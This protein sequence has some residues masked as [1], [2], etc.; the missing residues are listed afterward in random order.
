MKNK[1]KLLKNI[2]AVALVFALTVTLFAPAA[3]LFF[4][5]AK[6]SPVIS[7]SSIIS[8]D[9]YVCARMRV[10]VSSFNFFIS[11]YMLLFINYHQPSAV[12]ILITRVKTPSS[13][14]V[15]ISPS[16]F[17]VVVSILLSPKP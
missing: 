13:H 9:W 17:F 8:G 16:Y 1:K 15:S 3:R 11:L 7:A 10:P 12:F 14:Y 5:R 2:I 4:A 6:E